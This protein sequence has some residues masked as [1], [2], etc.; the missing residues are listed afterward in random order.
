V[1]SIASTNQAR[2]AVHAE[3]PEAINFEPV[4]AG[5]QRIGWTYATGHHTYGWILDTGRISTVEASSRAR[6]E[7]NARATHRPRRG[8]P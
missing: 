2:D 3:H 5:D 4:I 7:H 6:A 1:N 8:T